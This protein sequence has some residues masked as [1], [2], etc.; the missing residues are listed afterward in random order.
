MADP[1]FPTGGANPREGCENVLFG[2]IFAENCMKMREIGLRGGTRP[3]ATPGFA[4][5]NVARKVLV[6]VH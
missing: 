4:T 1:G 3:R 2:N 6:S 5:A